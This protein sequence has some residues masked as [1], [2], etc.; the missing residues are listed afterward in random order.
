MKRPTALTALLLALAL[1][2]SACGGDDPAAGDASHNDADVAFAQGMIPHHEQALQ[3]ARMAE[4]RA[5]DPEVE[6][7]A[8]D[9][10]GAQQ[11]EIDTM[12]GW[13]QEW[14]EEV[15]SDMGHGDMGHGTASEMPGMMTAD[16][17]AGL[18]AADGEAWDRMFLTMMIEHHEGAVEMAETEV[19]DGSYPD[20][21]EMAEEIIEVQQAEIDQMEELL[22]S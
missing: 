19:A 12:T 11:G 9:I 6:R 5:S 17:M 20:A 18:E 10:E 2:V 15:T 8:A 4:E 16:E 21:V 3:M 14:D 7:L 1:A 13:L 22:G